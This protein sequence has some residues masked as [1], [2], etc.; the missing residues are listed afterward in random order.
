MEDIAAMGAG[1]FDRWFPDDARVKAERAVRFAVERAG[2]YD[3]V[4]R[5]AKRVLRGYRRG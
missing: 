1:A 2:I 5:A 3:Q 4:K